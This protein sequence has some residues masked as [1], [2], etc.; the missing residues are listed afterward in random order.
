[1]I[2]LF[3]LSF[4]TA[5]HVVL[6]SGAT[7]TGD[8]REASHLAAPQARLTLLQPETGRRWSTATRAD[9][10]YRIEGLPPGRYL[11]SVEYAGFVAPPRQF[12]LE[13]ATEEREERITL[14]LDK[15]RTEVLV[16]ATAAAVSA[17]SISRAADVVRRSDWLARGVSTLSEA[18]QQTPGLRVQTLG[19]PGGFTRLLMRG[20]RAQDTA[21]TVEGLRFRDAATTQG[22][23]TPF[24]ENLMLADT[25]RVE[26][27]RGSG[28][29]L[30]GTNAVGGVINI[31]T[32][33][34]V[35]SWR[36]TMTGEGGG[37]GFGRGLVQL[38]GPLTQQLFFTGGLQ[39]TNVSSGND[40]QDPF[41]NTSLQSSL[42]WRPR[43]STSLTGRLYGAD[44]FAGINDTPFA[45]PASVLPAQG[46]IR[47]RPLTLA[48]QRGVEAGL[49]L[50]FLN[51]ANLVPNLNDPDSHRA[52]RFAATALVLT[53]QLAPRLSVRV[54]YQNVITRRIFT[55]G[56]AG[57]RLEPA[58]RSEDRIRGQ[59]DTV[60]A[61]ID[62][63]ATPR[64]TIGGGYEWE[65]EDYQSRS[66][67]AAPQAFRSVA[68]AGQQ[69]AAMIGYAEGRLWRDRLHL[70]MA[71][72]IQ[73]FAL[74]QPEFD[75]GS[76]TFNGQTFR[77]PPVARTVDVGLAWFLARPGT[78]LRVHA[79]NGYRSPSLF[80]RFGSSFTNG[81]FSANGDPRLRPDRTVSVDA[82]VDQYL[83]Q[84]RVRATA[85]AFYTDLREVIA[86]DSSGFLSAAT[87]PFGRSSGYINTSGGVARGAETQLELTLPRRIR[88]LTSYTYTRA[89]LRR[90]TVRDNDFYTSPLVVPHQFTSVLSAPL[91]RRLDVTVSAWMVASHA[92]I[93]SRRAFLF[94]GG[95]RLD[96]AAAYRMPGERIPLRLQLK[97]SNI[98]NSQYLENGFRATGFWA[99]A[100]FSVSF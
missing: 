35:N 38:G 91:T 20:L 12:S 75:G 1:V 98:L 42:A 68:L 53:H 33:D 14:S 89:S 19:G 29:A 100:G 36:G 46:A 8:V 25:Q 23:A 81:A 51:G 88:S 55:D 5:L 3:L 16:T 92:T 84:N 21:V 48:Q 93:L 9:G 24:V 60:Q 97:A 57:V 99:T 37:L 52:S 59:V 95:R 65:R 26:V 15:V 18:V 31:V 62:L 74:R 10:R 63:A 85:T 71:G 47:A 4:S 27:L 87:D 94:D 50:A 70:S 34:T 7:L 77:S 6:L 78:K 58:F 64:W 82:G 30:Y 79:G 39:H 66:S 67:N 83:W 80:E 17:D 56:P 43:G 61:R 28:S 32:E 11:V 49:P 2:R 90:S 22:D 72:R 96:I 40:G 76:S 69:S 13:T 86:F 41:R 73:R 54:S 45:G 44:A